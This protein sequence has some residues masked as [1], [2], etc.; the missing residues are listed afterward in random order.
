MRT[1]SIHFRTAFLYVDD[2]SS[3]ARVRA[4]A[5]VAFVMSH[6]YKWDIT[7]ALGAVGADPRRFRS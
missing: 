1:Y 6:L 3:A 4:R 7:G 2:L 5:I